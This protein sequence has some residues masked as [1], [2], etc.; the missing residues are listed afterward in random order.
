MKR[1]IVGIDL[2][3]SNTVVAT[4]RGD[5]GPIE[6]VPIR[7]RATVTTIEALELFASCAYAA[8]SGEIEIDPALGES[9]EWILGEAAKR[10]G[11]EVPQRLV[12]SSKSWLCHPRVDKRAP[13]LP[14][15]V[16]DAPKLSPVEM[17]ERILRRIRTAWDVDHPDAPLHQQ[18]VV[19]TVPA[20]FDEVARELTFE[21]ARDAGLVVRLLEEPQAAFYAAMH[22]RGLGSL[23]SWMKERGRATAHVLVCDVGGGTT[24]LSLLEVSAPTDARHPDTARVRRVAVGSHLLL[25]GDNMDLALAHALEPRLATAPETKLDPRQFAELTMASRRAKE[26]LFAKDGPADVKIT[27]LGRG[28]QLL[29]STKSTRLGRDEASK[30]VLDGFLPIVERSAR[31]VR[32]R[33]ALVA[34]G[35]PYERDVAMTRHIAAFVSRHL[36]EGAPVD[37]LL[38]NGGVFRAEN[39]AARVVECVA[40]WQA[41][42]PIV[43]DAYDP[44]TAV[45]VGAVVFGLALRGRAPRITGGSAKSYFLGVGRGGDGRPLAVCAV[46]K[47]SEEGHRQ[48]AAQTPLKLLV[49]KPARFEVYCS[50]EVGAIEAGA[51]VSVDDERFETLPPLSTTVSADATTRGEVEVVLEAELTPIGTLEIACVETTAAQEP[52]RH[53]LAFDLRA[54]AEPARGPTSKRPAKS[55]DEALAAISRV[56]EKGTTSEARDAKNLP[57]EL[58]RLLGERDEWSADT[59]RALADRLVGHVKGRKR[60]ADHERVY[61]QLVGFCLRPGYGAPGDEAR[62]KAM[63]PIFSERIGFQKEARTWQQFF[64]CFRRIAA[65]LDERTQ[66]SMRDDLDP[67]IAPSELKM[68]KPKSFKPESSDYEILELLGHLERVPTPRRADLGAWILERTWTKRDPRLW[69]AI[70]RL[71]ARVP[72][73]ASLHHVV[74]PVV[75]EKWIDHLLRDKWADLATAPRAACDMARFTG[76]RARDVSESV[77]NEV[78]RRLERENADPGLV[79]AVREIVEV[80]EQE[81]AAF[82]G[83]R[84]P[85]G[86]SL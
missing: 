2:G 37:A 25:G 79:R 41:E 59:T 11:A 58:E 54:T 36:P 34:F 26:T 63:A 70:G 8:Q 24:D 82:Y 21:A 20:S 57:R 72:A 75:V 86:L 76:D 9:D 38:L 31:P 12:A 78:A 48:R 45:A 35:L 13:I 1:R 39:I 10:R 16:E 84:L 61:F 47:G 18:D 71:G 4:A 77:R 66:Q 44:D 83:E 46:P 52:R 68:K 81:R 62:C 42:P 74:S 29:G 33:T 32:T 30:V 80:V 22:E 49:G 40:S 53:R 43:L 14:W 17:A 15:G 60:T 56:Y 67:F 27:L 50:D 64:I 69:A 7:Q 3:T 73:Y 85:S 19:L 55:I 51:I 5:D 65:G 6:V 23:F 28:S